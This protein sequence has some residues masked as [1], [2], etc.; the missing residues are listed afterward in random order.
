MSATSTA[1]LV[2]E[3]LS[4][5]F[6]ATRALQ[7]IDFQVER[8]TVRALL[9]H[10]G[11]GKSTLIKTLGGYHTPDEGKIY[12]YGTELP[13]KHSGADAHSAGLRFVHQDL[14][15]VPG[16]SVAENLALGASYKTSAL[17]TI[18]WREQNRRAKRELHK[19]H[20][21]ID[22][23]RNVENLGPV[24]RTLVAI[25]RALQDMD[26]HSGV[27]VLDEPTARLPRSEVN[28]LLDI[29]KKLKSE[30]VA[31]IYVTHRL[32]E[33]FQVADDLTVLRDG[34]RIFS[35][36]IAATDEDTV[37]S[38]IAGRAMTEPATRQGLAKAERTGKVVAELHGLSGHRTHDVDLRLY[39]G[40]MVAIVGL[41]GSG[42]SELGRL[43]YGLQPTTSGSISLREGPRVAKPTP[44]WAS[45]AGVGYVPQERTSGL[46]ASQ[47][48]A[49]NLA[50]TSFGGL[51]GWFGVS[52]QKMLEM[53][54]RVVS[55]FGVKP[56]DPTVTIS[57]LS[58]GNQQKIALGKWTRLDCA[59]LI[60]DEPLQGIDVGAKI[61][62]LKTIRERVLARG[63][64]VL[65]LESDIEYVP[66]YADRVLVM[67]DGRIATEISS[68]PVSREDV[69]M[70]LYGAA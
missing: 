23:R 32:D 57:T 60:M 46:A 16:L 10:N 55:R 5:Q 14:G 2:I 21:D 26:H 31:V 38:L 39:A 66:A 64:A 6:G 41:V 68:K 48:I 19:L 65:W 62:I 30:G 37:R 40:E 53:G 24:E 20:L 9:G 11:S 18:S 15:L 42:R 51:V 34:Q 69:L 35:G 8:G 59:L 22:P 45:R 36:P 17:G 52:S 54:R 58:G 50:I 29:I 28:R 25:A 33:V 63:G 43:I 49:E 7:S 4:K 27:L 47:T 44:R 56:N 67:R 3:N 70:A 12:V 13:P 1:A 61:D